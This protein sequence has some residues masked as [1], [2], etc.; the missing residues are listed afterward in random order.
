MSK[1]NG[2]TIGG[3]AAHTECSVPTIRYYEEVGLLPKASRRESGH[4]IYG[5]ADLRRLTFIRRCRDFGF[6]VE[7][8]RLLVELT[9]SPDHDCRAARDLASTQLTEVRKKLKELRELERSLNGFVN[10]CDARCAGGPAGECV[11]LE[12]LAMPKQGSCCGSTRVA[13]AKQCCAS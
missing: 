9:A 10:A 7:Q 8:I 1:S 5:E 12:D 11:I 4:R 13:K 3:L 6:P 2:M